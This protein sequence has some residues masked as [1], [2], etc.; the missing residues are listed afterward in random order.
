MKTKVLLGAVALALVFAAAPVVAQMKHGEMDHSGHDMGQGEMQGGMHGDGMG[1]M[2]MGA[3]KGD[4]S[5]SSKDYA[6]ANAKMH[7]AM[8]IV[9]TGDSDVDFVKGMIAHHQGAI[10]MAEVVLQHG[11]DPEIRTLAEGIIKAQRGEIAMMQK[12]LADK[13]K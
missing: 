11:K 7:Q 1:Q 4:D 3:P 13:G 2:N 6:A 12:W 10:D 8:D 9:F 5:Q